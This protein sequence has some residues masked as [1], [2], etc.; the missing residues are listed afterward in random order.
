MNQGEEMIQPLLQQQRVAN[1]EQQVRELQEQ[2]KAI[3]ENLQ[4]MALILAE[5]MKAGT[6]Q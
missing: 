3:L 1:L 6:H 4:E 2:N 5:H